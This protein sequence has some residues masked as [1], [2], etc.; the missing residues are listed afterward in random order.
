[1]VGPAD[2]G[3]AAAVLAL[4]KEKGLKVDGAR[5]ELIADMAIVD[6]TAGGNPVE[7]TLEAAK[8]LYEESI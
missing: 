5:R 7:L 6:P 1:M 8:K 2:A 4:A 3:D